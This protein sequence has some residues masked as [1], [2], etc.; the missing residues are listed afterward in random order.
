MSIQ[1]TSHETKNTSYRLANEIQKL[2]A[3]SHLTRVAQWRHFGAPGPVHV[4]RE[5]VQ[6]DTSCG[7]FI[8]FYNTLNSEVYFEFNHKGYNKDK[9][10][11]VNRWQCEQCGANRLASANEYALHVLWFNV[12]PHLSI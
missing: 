7:G 11:Q 3:L 10:C 2:N 12:T 4:F 8:F 6:G 1:M 5:R 9:R